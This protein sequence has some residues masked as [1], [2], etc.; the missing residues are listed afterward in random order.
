MF[1]GIN[2]NLC[3]F[4]KGGHP[5]PELQEI[6]LLHPAPLEKRPTRTNLDIP[7]QRGKQNQIEDGRGQVL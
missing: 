5:Q 6:D 4:Q 1:T 2:T 3:I 7:E